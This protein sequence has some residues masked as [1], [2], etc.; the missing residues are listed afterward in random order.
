M[1]KQK[2]DSFRELQRHAINKINHIANNTTDAEVKKAA[3]NSIKEIVTDKAHKPSSDVANKPSYYSRFI[4]PVSLSILA[5]LLWEK[6]IKKVAAWIAATLFSANMVV[7]FATLHVA[8]NALL[9]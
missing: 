4:E 2:G 1:T 7:V 5:N 6:G 3:I 9:S 8:L